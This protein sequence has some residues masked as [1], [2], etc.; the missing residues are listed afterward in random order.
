MSA[1]AEGVV[2]Y[3][4][5]GFPRLSETFIANE[6]HQL[7]SAGLRLR[8]YSVKGGEHEV[9]H[10]VVRRIR[11]P[12]EYLPEMTPLTGAPLLGWLRVNFP[13]VSRAHGRLV[14]RRPLAYVATLAQAL[15]MCWRRSFTRNCTAWRRAT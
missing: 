2:A 14:R 7:E 8:L 15:W 5:K 4:L 13:R 12:I 11:A 1:G 9:V 3:V 10:D 6:I